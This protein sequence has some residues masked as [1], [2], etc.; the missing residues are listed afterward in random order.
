MKGGDK[1]DGKHEK[2]MQ[3]KGVSHRGKTYIR[4]EGEGE[5]ERERKTGADLGLQ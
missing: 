5:G 3:L 1:V 2:K 4:R